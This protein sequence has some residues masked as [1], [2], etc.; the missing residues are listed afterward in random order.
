MLS[1]Q[2]A[3]RKPAMGPSPDQRIRWGIRVSRSSRSSFLGWCRVAVCIVVCVS[4]AGRILRLSGGQQ[5]NPSPPNRTRRVRVEGRHSALRVRS[6]RRWLYGS[7]SLWRRW[8]CG[9]RRAALELEIVL[10]HL[11]V[12]AQDAQQQRYQR[13]SEQRRI[14]IGT[15]FAERPG[16]LATGSLWRHGHPSQWGS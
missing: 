14:E 13:N 2:Q 16:S 10:L 6:H 12:Q 11:Q 1:Q 7:R 5:A 15:R 4:V 9:G 8:N 3:K